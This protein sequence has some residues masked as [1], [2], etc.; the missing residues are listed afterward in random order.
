[1]LFR[2]EWTF[3]A[4]L[5]DIAFNSTTD[6][7]L[8]SWEVMHAPELLRLGLMEFQAYAPNGSELAE[9]KLL[10]NASTIEKGSFWS[11]RYKN[12]YFLL[13]LVF[14]LPILLAF[15]P[16]IKTSGRAFR[17]LVGI[18]SALWGLSSGLLGLLLLCMPLLS[19]RSYLY[20]SANLWI[21]W[22]L[23]LCLIV[24]GIFW[25]LGKT[26][27]P[28]FLLYTQKYTSYAHMGACLIFLFLAIFQF[29]D[30]EIYHSLTVLMPI[31]LLINLLQ[32]VLIQ[33]AES[34]IKSSGDES[35][36][37][38]RKEAKRQQRKMSA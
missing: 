12:R 23:D 35:S 15:L 20:Y 7:A 37:K 26:T 17:L 29:F 25:V 38:L 14:L 11:Y 30:Q 22:P 13:L 31:S 27:L 16:F 2:S 24:T 21:M 33:Q 18:P 6:Q 32:L 3:L 4:T 19:Y 36:S 8:S 9:K 34:Q 5:V 28:K 1:M 10:N